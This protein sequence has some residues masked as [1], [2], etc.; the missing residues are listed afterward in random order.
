MSKKWF[1]RLLAVIGAITAAM[2]VTI[3]VAAMWDWCEVDPTLNIGGHIVAL[4]ASMQGDPQQI[5]GQISFTVSVPR[6]TRVSVLS[7]EK[8]AKVDIN[9]C[10][11]AWGNTTPV[12][13]SVDIK[14]KGKTSYKTRLTVNVDGG[15]PTVL[16]ESTTDRCLNGTFN[17]KASNW[18]DNGWFNQF[19]DFNFQR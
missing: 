12:R 17:L 4:Q 3:P 15:A 10:G 19:G 1:G 16:D 2:L 18:N 14:T 7:V 11:V 8:G 9:Y 13:V 5:C 6:G